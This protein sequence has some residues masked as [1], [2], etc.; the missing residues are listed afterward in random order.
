MVHTPHCR[1]HRRI[2]TDSGVE[3]SIV[4]RITFFRGNPQRAEPLWLGPIARVDI[5]FTPEKILSRNLGPAFARIE[6]KIIRQ[7]GG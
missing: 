4:L 6:D 2:K 7:Y 1:M 3:V 5:V